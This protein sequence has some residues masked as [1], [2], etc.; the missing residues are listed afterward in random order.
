MSQAIIPKYKLI[1]QYDINQATHEV[2]YQFVIGEFVPTLQGMGLYM[3]QVYHTAYG[4]YPVRQIEFVAENLETIRNA[5]NSEA[6]KKVYGKLQGYI[7]NYS[8]KIVTFR[9]AFQF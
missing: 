8:H 2:Y 3:L 5:M 7:S 9:D 1:M 6:Y 4:Q